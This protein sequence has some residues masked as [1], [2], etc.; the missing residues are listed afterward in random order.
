MFSRI[1]NYFRELRIKADFLKYEEKCRAEH[2]QHAESQFSTEHL[3]KKIISINARIQNEAANLFKNK[4]SDIRSVI[5]KIGSEI[6]HNEELIQLLVRDYKNELDEAYR[7][8]KS[9]YGEKDEAF[10]NKQALHDELSKAFDRKKA[11]YKSV[12]HYQDLINSWYARSKRTTLLFGKKGKKIPKHSIFGQSQGDLDSYK[13]DRDKAY[14][15]VQKCKNEIGRIKGKIENIKTKIDDIKQN[16]GI[17]NKKITAIKAD[18]SSMYRLIKQGYKT[19]IIENKVKSLK[20]TL[21][22]NKLDLKEQ[23]L[24]QQHYVDTKK[25]EYGVDV[26]ESEIDSMA[27][28]KREFIRLFENNDHHVERVSKHRKMWLNKRNFG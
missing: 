3:E 23:E 13:Y 27:S 26:L 20:S 15:D 22:Q 14:E 11:A 25:H 9:L 28:K 8:K 16:I 7:Q 10:N 12:N 21:E 19:E 2:I 24:M 18:R 6:N 17:I 5:V 4:I 1:A